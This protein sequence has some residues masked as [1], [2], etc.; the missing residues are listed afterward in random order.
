MPSNRASISRVVWAEVDR[1]R[2]ARSAAVRSRRS[3]R[4]LVVMSFLYLRLNSCK[5][6]HR[7][8]HTIRCASRAAVVAGTR[9]RHRQRHSTSESQK[10]RAWQVHLGVT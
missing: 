10:I 7:S 3:A 8:Q 4:A 5:H 6:E 1:V 2:F 9:C